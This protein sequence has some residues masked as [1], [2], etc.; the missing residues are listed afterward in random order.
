MK[1]VLNNW[2]KYISIIIGILAISLAIIYITKNPD[3]FLT[4]VL[5]WWAS[6]SSLLSSKGN[7]FTASQLEEIQGIS[8]GWTDTITTLENEYTQLADDSTWNSMAN[9]LST[10]MSD[11]LHTTAN[12]K[13]TNYNDFYDNG[14]LPR[15]RYTL[16]IAY[17]TPQAGEATAGWGDLF[18]AEGAV[19][20]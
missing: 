3:L 10:D 2:K 18:G 17:G 19:S 15:Y 13:Y 5:K 20:K 9:S 7:W 4:S 12:G 16:S 14:F 8:D 1:K 6:I 11:I